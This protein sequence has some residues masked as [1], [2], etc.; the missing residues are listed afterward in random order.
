[1]KQVFSTDTIWEQK[2]AYS[3]AI[4]VGNVVEVAG[5]TAVLNDKIMHPRNASKQAEVIFGKIALALEKVGAKM[6]DVIRTRMYLTNINDFEA[7]GKIHG[8]VF[9]GINPVSTLLEV[10]ALVDPKLVVE[11]EVSAIIDQDA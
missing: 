3:R 6:Q 10:S 5:T 1:M 2:V 8:I 9:K 7:V 11:I 4:R